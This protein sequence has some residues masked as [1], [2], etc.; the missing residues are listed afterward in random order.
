M[1]VQHLDGYRIHYNEGNTLA[2][3]IARQVPGILKTIRKEN[4]WLHQY[5]TK[6]K[7]D[8]IISDNRYG[9]HHSSIPSVI[10][11]HQL[12]IQTGMGRLADAMLQMLHYKYLNRF[13][14]CWVADVPGNFNLGGRL[15]HPNH[16][17]KNTRYIGLLSQFRSRSARL[18]RGHLLVLLSG[19][20]PQRTILHNKL[21]EQVKDLDQKVV[22]IAGSEHSVSPTIIPSN[23]TYHPILSGEPLLE[24]LEN[25]ELV[26]CRSGYSTLMDLAVSGK[27]AITIPTPG[28]TE[29]EYLAAHLY[30]QGIHY[31]VDQNKLNLSE[32]LEAV[33]DFPFHKP[34][35]SNGFSLHQPVIKDW[36]DSL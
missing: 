11:T 10:I 8:G 7:I 18:D 25:A 17:P 20:E 12:Q 35:L 24:E 14:Q 28:Q 33:K 32:A 2:N 15:S 31:T 5:C 19:P 26:I 21:W 6:H 3:A 9:L 1:D 23:I 13:S 4:D 30:K 29:Q 36:I 34:D 27:S 22:F 16:L